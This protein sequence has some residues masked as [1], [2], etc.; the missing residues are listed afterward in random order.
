M[1]NVYVWLLSFAT[2]YNII[3]IK[4]MSPIRESENYDLRKVEALIKE[5][6]EQRV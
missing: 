6:A 4:I 5:L 1:P 2:I 3:A